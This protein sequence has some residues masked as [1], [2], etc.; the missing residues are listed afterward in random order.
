ME[1]ETRSRR[2]R[3]HQRCREAPLHLQSLH[4]RLPPLA[5]ADHSSLP[6]GVDIIQDQENHGSEEGHRQCLTEISFLN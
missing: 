4:L 5:E 2:A 1:A 6:G 3:L